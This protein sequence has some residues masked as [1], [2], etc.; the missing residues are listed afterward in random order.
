MQRPWEVQPRIAADDFGTE[1]LAKEAFLPMQSVSTR[2]RGCALGSLTILDYIRN[3][4]I[5]PAKLNT[6]YRN[7]E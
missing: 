5:P 3:F 4:R 6:E 2:R 1:R 7:D